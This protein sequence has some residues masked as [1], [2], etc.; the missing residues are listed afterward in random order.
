MS[1]EV[2]L[3]NVAAPAPT[4]LKSTNIADFPMPQ[5]REEAWRFTPIER[6]EELLTEELTGGSPKYSFAGKDLEL[7]SSADRGGI[8]AE[9]KE[10]LGL[11]P[12]SDAPFDRA[13]AAGWNNIEQTLNLTVEGDNP[14]ILFVDISAEAKAMVGHVR[15]RALPNSHAIVVLRHTGGGTLNE[16]VE[17]KAEDGAKLDVVSLQDWDTGAK[18][19]AT[20][21]IT[22]G[23]E[24]EVKHG[25]ITLGGDVVRIGMG[26][27]LPEEH[28]D[29]N[30][31][32]LY[33][34]DAGQ[35][36]EHRLFIEHVASSSKSRVT[37][38]GAL[39]GQAAHAV[40]VGDVGIGPQ[41]YGT[42]SYELNRNLV[43]GKGP[44]V[45]SVPNLEIHNGQI[46]GAGH[47][48]ATGRFDDEQLFYLM[49]RG[50]DP[51]E[52]KRLVVKAFYAELLNEMEIPQLTD[53]VLELVDSHLSEG[54][55]K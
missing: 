18:H 2:T 55:L 53:H 47:A 26:A 27:Q 34:T 17:I 48:S 38:K 14:E 46:E 7:G 41:A 40:W 39:Q 37:Y 42:D 4:R 35:H 20:H 25:V 30:L 28:A 52:A 21:E 24:A 22:L 49:S 3:N 43:L 10:P 51:V 36:Q 19:V 31:L 11:A 12:L 16:T 9:L 13:G 1:N 45:D 6:L 44:R 15:V 33:F 29:L 32:G 23:R 50:I 5:A 8:L 54:S